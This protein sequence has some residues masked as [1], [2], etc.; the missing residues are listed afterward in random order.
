MADRFITLKPADPVIEAVLRACEKMPDS[1]LVRTIPMG[2]LIAFAHALRADGVGAS[3]LG[4][5][6]AAQQG[7]KQ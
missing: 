7:D 4:A 2:E 5:C 6:D 3:D 1:Q